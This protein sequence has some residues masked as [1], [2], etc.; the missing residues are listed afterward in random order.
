LI[1]NL[2]G[3]AVLLWLGCSYYSGWAVDLRCVNQYAWTNIMLTGRFL[4]PLLWAYRFKLRY[5]DTSIANIPAILTF[6]DGI[7]KY[8]ISISVNRYVTTR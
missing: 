7:L 6:P 5:T 2:V 8:I 1:T 4:I 3:Y